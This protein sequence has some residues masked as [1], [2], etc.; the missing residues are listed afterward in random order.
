MPRSLPRAAGPGRIFSVTAKMDSAVRTAIAAM[1]EDGWTPISYPRAIWDDQLRAWV[2][3]AEVAE[4]C[5]TAFLEEGPGHH[6]PPDRAPGP[7]P[8]AKT[9]GGQGELF[10]AWRYHAIFT[11]SPFAML[12]AEDHHRDHAV[13]EQV[14]ADWA[15][16]PLAHLPPGHFP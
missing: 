7:R 5:Y 1:P 9:G 12:Q 8:L 3:D 15:D 2:S 6:R 14:F 11:D 13:V 10:P 4:T 16:G